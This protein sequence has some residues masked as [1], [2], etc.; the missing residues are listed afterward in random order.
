MTTIN[1]D[2]KICSKVPLSRLALTPDRCTISIRLLLKRNA[3][4][5]GPSHPGTKDCRDHINHLEKG[6]KFRRQTI[7][8]ASSLS[9]S[10]KRPFHLR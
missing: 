5:D 7:A 4:D 3:A 10:G 8:S 6:G 9:V 2:L 1:H